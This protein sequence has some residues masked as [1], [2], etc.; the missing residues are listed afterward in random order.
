[1]SGID[2]AVADTTRG[3]GQVKVSADELAKLA[4]GLKALISQ[5]KV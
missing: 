1:M 4:E 5:F 2:S 3:I